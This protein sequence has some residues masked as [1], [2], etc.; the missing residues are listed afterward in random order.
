MDQFTLEE[1]AA[2]DAMSEPMRVLFAQL[3]K[4]NK[5]LR[6]QLARANEELAGANAELDECANLK[7]KLHDQL[8][9]DKGII[10]KLAGD[11]TKLN[12]KLDQVLM[13]TFN[14]EKQ[15]EEFRR[16][17]IGGLQNVSDQLN[18]GHQECEGC[19]SVPAKKATCGF[20][21]S[22]KANI[23]CRKCP[24]DVAKIRQK[25]QDLFGEDLDTDDEVQDIDMELNASI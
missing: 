2:H 16:T 8:I 15:L 13:K 5:R 17:V 7:R 1:R 9:R 10:R 25:C 12:G 19:M 23:P 20:T 21:K 24:K 22:V 6:E 18:T 3:R 14:A 11:R 4:E